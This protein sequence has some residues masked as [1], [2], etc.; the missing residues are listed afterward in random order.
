MALSMSSG[1][2]VVM[3][4]TSEMAASPM[5]WARQDFPPS[6]GV[7]FELTAK[8]W[9]A[10]AHSGWPSL[11]FRGHSAGFALPGLGL[12]DGRRRFDDA[13]GGGDAAGAG[14]KP[15]DLTHA[16]WLAPLLVLIADDLM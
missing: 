9:V 4:H 11:S 5:Y 1:A 3:L 8:L 6:C 2:K 10:R 15:L 14:S 13:G 16:D 7:A 12:S